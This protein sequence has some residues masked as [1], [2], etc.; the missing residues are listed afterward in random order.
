MLFKQKFSEL[1]MVIVLFMWCVKPC[2]SKL[3]NC[4]FF[5]AFN[6]C[7][8]YTLQMACCM[9][10]VSRCMLEHRTI[11]VRRHV[12]TAAAV[13]SSSHTPQQTISCG[14]QFLFWCFLY[15]LSGVSFHSSDSDSFRSCCFHYHCCFQSEKLQLFW[16]PCI[17]EWNQL[18]MATLDVWSLYL[19]FVHL[20]ERTNRPA[21]H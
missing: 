14:C 3:M 12:S 5:Q 20:L 8:C 4:Y 2:H 13:D 6:T 10:G 19:F 9:D 7:L 15:I 1:V 18:A 16:K 17:Y 21:S 11:S